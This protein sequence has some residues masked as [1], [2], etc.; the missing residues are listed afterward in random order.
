MAHPGLS[1]ATPEFLRVVLCYSS[2]AS[3]TLSHSFLCHS[4]EDHSHVCLVMRATEGRVL[5][6]GA[7]DAP[8]MRRVSPQNGRSSSTPRLTHTARSNT[9]KHSSFSSTA[10]AREQLKEPS[11]CK[12]RA[13]SGEQPPLDINPPPPRDSSASAGMLGL[14]RPLGKGSSEESRGQDLP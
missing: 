10:A 3:A 6:P 7:R 5:V 4:Q 11:S 1:L 9:N 12:A 8:A 13:H 14:S 2:K